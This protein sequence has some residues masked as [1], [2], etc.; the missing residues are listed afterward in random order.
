MPNPVG[1]MEQ[2]EAALDLIHVP[3]ISEVPGA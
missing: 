1:P 3:I 2:G